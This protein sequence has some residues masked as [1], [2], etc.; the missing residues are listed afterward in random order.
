MNS[1]FKLVFS[2]CLSLCLH[3]LFSSTG[4]S[5]IRRN[6]EPLNLEDEKQPK[7]R[8]KWHYGTALMK[9]GLKLKGRFKY[10]AKKNEIPK[11]IFEDVE[12]IPG[13]RKIDVSLFQELTVSGKEQGLSSKV[14]STRFV[15]ID[16]FSDLLREV[17]TGEISL[18]DNSKV[19]DE[20]YKYLAKYLLIARHDK[21]GVAR[22]K[23]L[24]DLETLMHE[25]PYF[26]KS[27]KATGKYNSTD[28]RVAF[29]LVDLFN[30]G[31]LPARFSWEEMVVVKNNGTRVSG[32]GFIQPLDLRNEF[33]TS[34]HGYIHFY[35]SEGMKLF[36]DD[37]LKYIEFRGETY[38]KGYFGLTDKN[39]FGLKWTYGGVDYLV[40]KKIINRN[41]YFYMNRSSKGEDIAIL[42][43]L[44]GT[45]TRPTNE[46]ILRL[47]FLQEQ[48]KF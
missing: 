16:E 47:Q 15:W 14:D 32:N 40:T 39:F 24:N 33:N 12:N 19:V 38:D 27:A 43:G 34:S 9:T 31:D 5:Q 42:K 20:K 6:V 23:Q 21:H 22:I 35:D 25:R 36:R 37:E 10:L 8:Y 13:K 7:I 46:N 11:F 28:L 1:V 18:F 41:S 26:M 17:R 2:I 4:F 45:Y 48:G 29:Y 44:S 30:E 3:S